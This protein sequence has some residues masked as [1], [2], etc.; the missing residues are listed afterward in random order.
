MPT[1]QIWPPGDSEMAARIRARDWAAT[2]L[3][4][5]DEWPEE[6]RTVVE[7]MLAAPQIAS[8]AV[9]PKR[10]LLY[11]DLAGRQYG[12]RHPNTLGRPI[13]ESFADQYALIADFYDRV[14]AGESVR[15]P[16]Q[17]VD[18]AG[19]GVP[20][21][22]DAY[23]TPVR[24][25]EGD[26]IAAYAT[27]VAAGDRVRAEA[28]LRE[29]EERQAFLL[30]LSDVL[31]PMADPV[32]ITG[33][34][35]RLLGE[36]LGASRAYYAEWPHGE[37]YGGAASDHT[38]PGLPSPAGRYPVDAFRSAHDRVSQ[39]RTWIVDDASA[40]TE[41]DAAGRQYCLDIGV[42][43]WVEVPLLKRGQV[44]AV[45]CVVQNEPR[46]WS[47]TETRL[48]E[49]TAE[50]CWAAVE[51][52][53]A[54]AALRES[55]ERFRT[56]AD[57]GPQLVW[58]SVDHQPEFYNQ[59]WLD[60]TG[61]TLEESRRVDFWHKVVHPDDLPLAAR[62]SL[63]SA[64]TGEPYEAE[65]RLRRADGQYRW[66]IARAFR[67]PGTRRW[68]G[69]ATDIHDLKTVQNQWQTSEERFRMLAESIED[70]FYMTDLDQNALLY[71]SPA[72]ERI[73]GRPV[74]ALLRNLG[75]F[76]DTI[77]PDDH[78][79]FFADK[80][81]QAQ[82]NPVV[83][84]YRIVRPDGEVRWI[85]DRSFPVADHGVRR[86]AGIASDI[87]ARKLAEAALR[88]SDARLRLL[89][90]EAVDYAI[91]TVDARNCVD[92][93]PPGA[94]AVF[95]WTAEEIIGQDAAILFTPEDRRAG[96]PEAESATARAEGFA[97]DVRWHQRKDGSRVFISGSTRA[98]RG[99]D[100]SLQSLFKI[101]R[102]DTERRERE[103]ALRTSEERFR[104]FGAASA[105]ILWIRNAR[106]MR[107]EYVS[108]AFDA[109]Y[110]LPRGNVTAGDD[111]RRWLRVIDPEDRR[112]VLDAFR[113]VRSGERIV[114]EFRIRRP[115]DGALRWVRDTDFPLYD[116][117]GHVERIGGIGHDV[118]EEKEV[119]ERMAVLVAELQH[120]TRNLMGV[121][122]SVGEQTLRSSTSLNDF[123]P[124]FRD[125]MAA[126]A[127]VNGLLAR[128]DE[129]HR[130]TFDDLIRTEIEALGEVARD[131]G[132]ISLR[133]PSGVL[134]RSSTVQT[135]ALALHELATNAVK[136]GALRQAEGMQGARLT[137]TWKLRREG[138]QPWLHVDWRESGVAMPPSGA[139]AQ[140]GGAGRQLI[141]RALPYQ[142]G[143]RTAFVMEEDGVRCTIAVPVSEKTAVKEAADA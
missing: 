50:R 59:R 15:V 80:A 75:G 121:V 27:F 111:L 93:W 11:N 135:F 87:T 49:E 66:H 18:S 91:F 85:L 42:I 44:E 127:R 55:E 88:T 8:I 105:D 14:F 83:T 24:N 94:A 68:V 17:E 77:H 58:S 128:L 62:R 23:L 41:I 3:G 106:S 47:E 34:A 108:P 96:V 31:R 90:E 5:I 37:E 70:V 69:A 97:P 131:E 19:T 52:A 136:Y 38:A 122:R 133:G 54:D 1:Q 116:A 73:W 129:G 125:R 10:L 71:L 4:T 32:E 101:G 60:F 36:W 114:H 56:L 9:G 13:S 33:A 81:A 39:G 21:V 117:Q 109:V 134:L 79:R 64:E 120:R 35:S 45:L 137:V 65:Y 12:A 53:R 141:E 115:S 26:V 119:A 103:E 89:V 132:R 95:G 86:S 78:A 40:D 118:T 28:A 6:L 124:V 123:M 57:V 139:A 7:L 30:Q 138:D 16:A 143:A 113:H 74:A 110:G 100:G 76:V 29:G 104:Q 126:L 61:L 51:R 99:P 2:S 43:A 98:L 107:F 130:I 25:G 20:E 102:D 92:S 82:G 142:L 67:V 22:Y 48:I 84:E 46:R 112:G 140:G 72:Y 63:R